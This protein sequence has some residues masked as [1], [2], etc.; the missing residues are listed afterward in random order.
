MSW[1]ECFVFYFTLGSA[2]ESQL[3]NLSSGAR[4]LLELIWPSVISY[5]LIQLFTIRY[6]F[7]I[8][9]LCILTSIVSILIMRFCICFESLYIVASWTTMV[10]YF[11]CE[12]FW[13]SVSVILYLIWFAPNFITICYF[14][15]FKS[16]MCGLLSIWMVQNSGSLQIS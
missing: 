16:D 6:C 13:Y 4:D 15:L 14:E 12:L 2:W 9:D 5:L 1:L 7:C 10:F 3:W 8:S 11:R